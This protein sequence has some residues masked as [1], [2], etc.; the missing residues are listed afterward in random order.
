MDQTDI[1]VLPKK[2]VKAFRYLGIV[3]FI[4][5]GFFIISNGRELDMPA[6]RILTTIVGSLTI[7]SSI[8]WIPHTYRF[9]ISFG[10][11]SVK[12][13][14][15]LSKEILYRNI[16]KLVVRKGFVEICGD[17]VFKRISIGDLYN[18]FNSATEILATKIKDGDHV[19]F[20][21]QKKYIDKYFDT[22][23]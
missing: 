5:V 17:G 20:A 19:T 23:A 3:I 4:M 14:G 15:L 7:L 10:P 6:L 1:E 8:L 9:R 18:N 16:E 13:S 11:D 22:T 12:Q 21:G 2:S